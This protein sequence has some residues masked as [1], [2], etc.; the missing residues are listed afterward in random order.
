MYISNDSLAQLYSHC[1]KANALGAGVSANCH[2][3]LK[4]K[5]GIILSGTDKW[6]TLYR[7]VKATYW[8]MWV[9]HCRM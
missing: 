5:H 7:G 1:V 4:K 9:I 3:N 2:K 6:Y 8:K